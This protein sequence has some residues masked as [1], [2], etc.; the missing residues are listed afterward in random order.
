MPNSAWLLHPN[1][2]FRTT[3]SHSDPSGFQA[4]FPADADRGSR[5]F[6]R[7]LL[8]T[9]VFMNPPTPDPGCSDIS[10]DIGHVIAAVNRHLRRHPL[11]KF[12]APLPAALAMGCQELQPASNVGTV[13]YAAKNVCPSLRILYG[14]RMPSNRIQQ[15]TW[16]DNR[17]SAPPGALRPDDTVAL[18]VPRAA[19][20]RSRPAGHHAMAM[21][22]GRAQASAANYA[23]VLKSLCAKRAMS[24]AADDGWAACTLTSPSL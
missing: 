21:A 23:C 10:H 17:A 15:I 1:H 7:V 22:M 6:R 13:D 24:Y 8:T 14:V 19:I 4:L 16:Y 5:P 20:H 18:T 11:S 12:E 9:S 3:A 2:A